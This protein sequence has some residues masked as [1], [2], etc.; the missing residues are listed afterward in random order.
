MWK[1]TFVPEIIFRRSIRL[2]QNDRTCWTI[3]SQSDEVNWAR[4]RFT[5]VPPNPEETAAESLTENFFPSRRSSSK[6]S[7]NADIC[8]F[9]RTFKTT[10]AAEVTAN[11]TH[12][13][14]TKCGDTT[15]DKN[16]PLSNFLSDLPWSISPLRARKFGNSSGRE[17]ENCWTIDL[18]ASNDI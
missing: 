8:R 18:S 3:L 5:L 17:N 2:K 1:S 4:R 13:K 14:T 15:S 7:L 10:K 6:A 16:F 12:T 9:I 11:T